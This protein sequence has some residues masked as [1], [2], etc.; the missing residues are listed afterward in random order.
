MSKE[1]RKYQENIVNQVLSSDKDLII[2]LPTGSGKTVIASALIEQL[3]GKVLFIVPR[4]ELIKQ[5][6]LANVCQVYFLKI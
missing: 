3:P 1:L 6:N 5:A 2:C 4:L